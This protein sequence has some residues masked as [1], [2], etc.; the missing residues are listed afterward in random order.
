MEVYIKRNFYFT[1]A[2][3]ATKIKFSSL[4]VRKHQYQFSFAETL[5]K[6]SVVAKIST[7]KL[8]SS[9]VFIIISRVICYCKCCHLIDF[10]ARSKTVIF[11]MFFSH[12]E[13]IC[14][15]FV[16]LI[17]LKQLEYTLVI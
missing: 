12:S 11:L 2:S 1:F 4:Y 17:L 3:L 14:S 5:R 7:R 16:S 6:F 9:S 13:T 8:K 10:S 15:I